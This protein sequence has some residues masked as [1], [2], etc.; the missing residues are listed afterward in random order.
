LLNTAKSHCFY[1]NNDDQTAQSV[2]TIQ[3]SAK[4]AHGGSNKALLNG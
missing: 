2:Q 1:L 3:D 4:I